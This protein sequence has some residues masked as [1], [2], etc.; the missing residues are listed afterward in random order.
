MRTMNR[1]L[2]LLTVA[3]AIVLFVPLQV[4]KAQVTEIKSWHGSYPEMNGSYPLTFIAFKGW[5][6]PTPHVFVRSWPTHYYIKTDALPVTDEA[7]IAGQNQTGMV[8][9]L[10]KALERTQMEG[11]MQETL[12]TKQ[13]TAL[14]QQISALIFDSRSDEI[15]DIYKLSGVFVD[16]YEKI[17]RLMSL[18]NAA[19]VH[20]LYVREADQLLV[21]F[22]LINLLQ[23]DHGSKLEAFAELHYT[24]DKLL[25]EVDYVYRKLRFFSVATEAQQQYAFLTQ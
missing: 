14:S 16:L 15:P 12:Q 9:I 18:E 13:Y 24:L 21:Q 25:G 1:I 6:V 17:N 4:L 5:L 11:R 10:L 22:A 19:R 3:A 20:A 7:E 8:R 2:R 23:A